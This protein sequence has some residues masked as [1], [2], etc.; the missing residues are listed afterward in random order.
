MNDLMVDI[1]TL[2][3]KPDAVIVQ[4]GACYFDRY[5]GEIGNEF[6]ANIDMQNCIDLGL[7]IDGLTL[8]FWFKQPVRTWLDSPVLSLSHALVN[9]QCFATECKQAWAHA[10]F[11]FPILLGAYQKLGLRLPFHF[12][13]MRDLRTLVD[14][15][16]VKYTHEARSDR[17]D[18]LADCKFQVAYA[19]KCFN[20]LENHND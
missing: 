4:I 10:N 12:R 18:A 19:I 17:H 1:E 8:E 6:L 5:T 20:K 16:K 3:Y 2:G 14:L 15:V 7:T 9:F 11:D 13:A